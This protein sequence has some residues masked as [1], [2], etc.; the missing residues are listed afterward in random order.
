M[1]PL[2]P[3]IVHITPPDDDYAAPA[4]NPILD[5]RLNDIREEFSNITTVAKRANG[6]P[7]NDVKELSDIK[8]YD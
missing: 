3:Q 5:R 1:K 6:N 4:T 2:T 8:T 7:V